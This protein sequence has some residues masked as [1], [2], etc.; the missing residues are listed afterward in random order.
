MYSFFFNVSVKE[1][2]KSK[3]VKNVLNNNKKESPRSK[4]VESGLGV[5]CFFLDSGTH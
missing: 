1:I 4:V 5:G 2:Q 3:K